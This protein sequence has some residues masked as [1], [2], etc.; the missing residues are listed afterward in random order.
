MLAL[1]AMLL[2][3]GISAQTTLKERKAEAKATKTALKKK[4]TKVARRDAKRYKKD[5]WTTVPGTLPL[6]KQIDKA[7]LMQYE[8]DETGYPKYIMGYAMTIGENFDAAKIQAVELAK[9]DIVA[10]IQEETT[11][12]VKNSLANKQLTAEQAA[13]ITQ[14]IVS[15]KSIMSQRLGRVLPVV[16]AYRTKENKNKEVLVRLAYSSDMALEAAKQVVR[17]QLEKEGKE[18]GKKV[19][20]A[21]DRKNQ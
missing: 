21:F 16:E 3:A 10:Q 9:Q 14:T 20:E 2:C 7:Y 5:G 11:A 15:S 19:D 12:L 4:A 13:S 17:E 6:D 1:S 18:L 8:Y